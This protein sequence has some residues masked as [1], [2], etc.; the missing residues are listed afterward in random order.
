MPNGAFRESNIDSGRPTRGDRFI[1]ITSG[2]SPRNPGGHEPGALKQRLTAELIR[3]LAGG[4]V[5]LVDLVAGPVVQDPLLPLLWIYPRPQSGVDH[6]QLARYPP[7]FGQK[8]LAFAGG[9]VA[10][11]MTSEHPVEGAVGKSEPQGVAYKRHA[12]RQAG[13]RD[14]D[15]GRTLIDTDHVAAKM[16]G[17]EAGAAGDIQRPPG[18]QA[19]DQH[20]E[21]GDLIVP[22][23]TVPPGEHS[24]PG[25]PLVVLSGPPIVVG[26]RRRIAGERRHRRHNPSLPVRPPP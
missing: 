23:R 14:G 19:L 8:G 4:E 11:E 6:Y 9:Q 16:P 7:R 25:V 22:A 3:E 2:H 26:S 21:L 1:R 12:A 17:Q 10:V 5:S 18:R 15:H 24:L 13:P 20:D